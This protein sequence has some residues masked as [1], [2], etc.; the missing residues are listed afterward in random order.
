MKKLFT[1]IAVVFVIITVAFAFSATGCAKEVA[2]TTSTT[3]AATETTVAET[4]QAEETTA[5]TEAWTPYYK[6][7]DFKAYVELPEKTK[8]ELGDVPDEMKVMPVDRVAPEP[9]KIA[10]IGAATNPFFDIIKQG[11]DEAAD[12][13]LTHNAR[14]E[15][16]VPGSTLAST[17]AGQAIEALVT[18]EYDAICTMIFN[19]GMI[20]YV[21]KAVD[22]GIPVA[23]VIV[24]TQ[25]NKS[26]FFTG[27]DLYNAGKRAADEMA[28]LIGEKG[29][30]GV[31]TGFFNVVGHEL[32]RKG[33]EDRVKEKY[34]DIKIV[35]SV[36]NQDLA[37]KARSQATDFMTAHPDLAGIYVTAGGPIGAAQAVVDAGKVG[38]VKIIAF[39]PLPQT[40]EYI[41]DGSIQGVIGQNPFAEGRDPAIRLFNYL[42]DGILPI[43][44]FLWT[45][46]DFVTKD[47]LEEFYASGQKG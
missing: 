30:V 15:W 16:I 44:R 24:D 46:A 26:L 32:R 45:R 21:D 23:A 31:I 39:D 33:F 3:A 28:K 25:P 13:L 35:G 18:Q 1:T 6:T 7:S 14:L 40:V 9:I 42:M 20:P 5:A 12:L 47:N 4:T 43:A 37:E 34:P 11:V 2:E 19:E 22:A 38:Q 17:D 27:Q 10:Y 36:E 8:E 29:K 41:K